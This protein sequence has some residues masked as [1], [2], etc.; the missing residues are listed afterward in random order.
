MIIFGLTLAVVSLFGLNVHAISTPVVPKFDSH[1]QSR[2]VSNNLDPKIKTT[3]QNSNMNSIWYNNNLHLQE[4][5]IMLPLV[6]LN[7]KNGFMNENLLEAILSLRSG[8]IYDIGYMMLF[9]MFLYSVNNTDA[10]AI[11][12]EIIRLNTLKRQTLSSAYITVSR[13]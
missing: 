8:D 7:S 2:I 5:K 9:V 13:C 4:F 1:S 12:E 6:Y 10:F 11:L 3:S